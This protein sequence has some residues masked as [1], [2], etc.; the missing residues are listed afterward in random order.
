MLGRFL[1]VALHAADSGESFD[2]YRRLGFEPALTGDVWA[3]PYGVVA[4]EGLALGLHG[5]APDRLALVF[6]RPNV[7]ELH[8]ELVARGVAISAA[9]LGSDAFNRLE[10][11]EATG[12]R[13]AVLEARSFSPPATVPRET[14]LGQFSRLSLPARD[15]RL[16][17]GF[18]QQLGVTPDEL[19]LAY[20]SQGDSPEPLLLFQHLDPEAAADKL[21]ARGFEPE[22][23]PLPYGEGG[24]LQLRS[25]EDQLLRVLA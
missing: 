21:E 10:L 17:Q 23:R 14:L 1:E 9:V 24:L 16:A 11:R 5:R 18:W 13:I 7:G 6:V 19:P 3:H 20:H 25:P 15:L 22:D 8:R 2:Y 4:C 12:V